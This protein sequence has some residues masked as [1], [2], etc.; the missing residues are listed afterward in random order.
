MC[1]EVLNSFR[2]CDHK[3]YQNTH[4]CRIAR[5]LAPGE[6]ALLDKPKFL[7]DKPPKLP[8]GMLQCKIRKATRPLDSGCPECKKAEI[9]KARAVSNGATRSSSL[10]SSLTTGKKFRVILDTVHEETGLGDDIRLTYRPAEQQSDNQPPEGIAAR[11]VRDSL[12]FLEGQRKPT[13]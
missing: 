13:N 1:T 6:E 10:A 11:R 7:P 3:V 12:I 9:R 4:L 2:G 5:R 8:P